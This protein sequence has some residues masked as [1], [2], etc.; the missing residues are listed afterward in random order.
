MKLL[1]AVQA[2]AHEADAR[3]DASAYSPRVILS[4][5]VEE[6]HRIEAAAGLEIGSAVQIYYRGRLEPSTRW[7]LDRLAEHDIRA[8]FFIVAEIAQH[9]P[10]LIRAIQAAGHEVASHSWSHQRV[11]SQTPESFREDLRKSKDALEQVT[12]AAVVGYRAPTFSITQDTAWA[13]DVLAEEGFLYDSSIYPIRHD[14][15]GVPAAPR[16]PFRVRGKTSE[17]LELPPA[18]LRILRS[19][20]PAGGGGYFRLLPLQVVLRAIEQIHRECRPAV[21]MLYFHPWEF[22]PAQA[23]LPLGRLN[24]FRTYVGINRSRDR[25]N[26][27]LERYDFT[28]AVDVARELSPETIQTFDLTA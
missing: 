16:L 26:R 7:L 12:G 25:F 23:R 5:D 8:T 14:R 6:H 22:D 3:R 1:G 11:H 24:R 20:L 19:R 17:I 15:Y 21:A 2:T 18:T 10:S 28:R 9:S 13:I 4:F 27:L